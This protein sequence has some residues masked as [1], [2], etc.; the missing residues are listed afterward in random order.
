MAGPVRTSPS[1]KLIW[2][3]PPPFIITPGPAM[4]PIVGPA[5]A[6]MPIP[7][8]RAGMPSGVAPPSGPPDIGPWNAVPS[9]FAPT[10]GALN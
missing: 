1:P 5:A 6:A 9:A 7:P 3:R 10:A 8:P 2:N 4:P